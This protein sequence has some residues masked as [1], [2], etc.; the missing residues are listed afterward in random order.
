MDRPVKNSSKFM[1]LNN[2]I[3]NFPHT[4]E[5]ILNFLLFLFFNLS[6]VASICYC[7]VS[8]P[9]NHLQ[10]VLHYSDLFFLI[11]KIS[12]VLEEHMVFETHH[13]CT[14]QGYI[15]VLAWICSDGMDK[16]S[17]DFDQRESYLMT[18]S[19]K[20]PRNKC[21]GCEGS[22]TLLWN[23]I[24]SPNATEHFVGNSDEL[25]LMLKRIAI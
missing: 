12:R 17:K 6:T 4:I 1:F 10:N 15:S 21:L 19:L 18:L 24:L 20:W 8:F 7:K 14:D 25:R 9:L 3:L 22:P 16:N 2:K 13:D 23:C 11:L 5:P